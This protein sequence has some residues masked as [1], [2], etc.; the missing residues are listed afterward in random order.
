MASNGNLTFNNVNKVTFE[1]VGTAPNAVFDTI[2]G[3]I[4][5]GIDNPV[6]NLH[7]LGNTYVS[8][9]MELGGTLIMG[10]VSVHSQHSLEAVTATGNTTPLTIEFSNTETAFVTTANVSIGD[11]LTVSGNTTVSSNLTVTG[12][13]T[14]ST[15]LGD[16]TLLTGVAL[17]TDLTDNASRITT[18]ESANT[19]QGGLITA[20]ETDV[21]DNA[22][23]ITTLES[24]NTVQGGLITAIETDLDSNANKIQFITSTTDSTVITSNLDITGNIFMRGDRFVVES[25]T[26]LI[27]DAVIGLAN[28]N[29]TA[30]TDTGLIMQRPEANVAL[31]H[32]GASGSE[33]A[34]HF[35]IGYTQSTLT[36]ADI[37]VDTA[38][39]ITVNIIGNLVTQNT[40]T[41]SYLHGDASNVTAVP[42]TQI[43][44]TL[45][46]ARI[47][48]LAA[49]K[50]TSGTL[51][52]ARI[53][54]L[55]AT[56]I[57]TGTLDVARIP[58]LNQNTT[59]SAGSA[60]TLTT[61]RSI[62]GVD[63]DGS[64]AIV[65]TT[66][67][68][69]T[70]SGNV[71]VD[72]DTL[73]VDSVNDRVGIGTGAPGALLDLYK[74]STN[75]AAINF[76]SSGGYQTTIGQKSSG[77][78]DRAL[79]FTSYGSAATSNPVYN[80]L[81]LNSDASAY[82]TI[83]TMTGNG[84]VGIGT[85]TPDFPLD[86]NGHVRVGDV[87]RI[88]KNDGGTTPKTLYFGGTYGDTEEGTCTIERRLWATGTENQELLLFSGNDTDPGSGS[89]R[90]RMKGNTILFDTYSTSTYDREAE[91]TKMKI[92]QNGNVDI[93]NGRLRIHNLPIASLS[94]SRNATL[95]NVD[96]TSANFYNK[97]WLNNGN[98]FNA[99]TGR[100]TCPG[101]GIYRIYFRVTATLGTN[102]RLR[103][104]G[105]GINEAYAASDTA[106]RS[107]SSEAV[108]ECVENDYLHIQ[109][110]S[111]TPQGGTQHCQV[112]FQQLG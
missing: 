83:L 17:S 59:G 108:I 94:D 40:I 106:Q 31:I 33:Y 28:N 73:F 103:K 65:P 48:S 22:S 53:P 111:L 72:T 69:A 56:K 97:T 86:V 19:V 13:V 105:S 101:P 30:T 4:G 109:V 46:V 60:A 96:L 35:T 26:K 3:K 18:L 102:V 81:A 99:S 42:A 27:N 36:D 91:T 54:S 88:G 67:G 89:D 38:N 63:F 79:Q 75:G 110:N 47:P 20:I 10:T 7:V 9:N 51:G 55:A 85:T 66:F 61:P 21:T 57:T 2:E 80:F 49:S 52:V 98:H 25:E 5:V 74:N 87:L 58:T 64:A 6:A 37:G 68:A 39:I 23:R 62:G 41:A 93:L 34:N 24:A 90:I 32:H 16:G 82:N 29:T 100:F 77:V 78:G 71:A 1:G 107:V 14:A 95:T 11:E 12:N 44:G 45:D 76:E 84:N 104:N 8:T 92:D 70:F 43:T 15:F 112:T 50:I